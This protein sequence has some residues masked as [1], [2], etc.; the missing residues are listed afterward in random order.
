[1][2]PVSDERLNVKSFHGRVMLPY[3]IVTLPTPHNQLPEYFHPIVNAQRTKIPMYEYPPLTLYFTT[4]M[5]NRA[6]EFGEEARLGRETPGLPSFPQVMLPL[7][8]GFID[9]SCVH[10]CESPFSAES[11]LAESTLW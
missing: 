8:L 5:P 4:R 3:H 1:M 2:K 11:P 10:W 6:N 7:Q 9:C